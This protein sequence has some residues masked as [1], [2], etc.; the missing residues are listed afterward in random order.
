MSESGQSSFAWLLWMVAVFVA[1]LE[2]GWWL[3]WS[4]LSG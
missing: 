4:V 2:L 3:F 1:S